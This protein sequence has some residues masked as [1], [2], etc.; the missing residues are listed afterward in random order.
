MEEEE[1]HSGMNKELGGT[2][3]CYFSGRI[4]KHNRRFLHPRL[5]GL[6]ECQK[7]S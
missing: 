6:S 4:E 3:N 2:I 7:I 5:K 1:K